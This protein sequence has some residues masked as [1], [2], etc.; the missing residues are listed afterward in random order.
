MM[1]PIEGI[2]H[3]NGDH[4]SQQDRID[5]RRRATDPKKDYENGGCSDQIDHQATG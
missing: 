5:N 2:L 1:K 4:G 3:C